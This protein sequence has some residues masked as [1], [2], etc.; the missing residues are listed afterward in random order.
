MDTVWEIPEFVV[1]KNRIK[2]VTAAVMSHVKIFLSIQYCG[3]WSRDRMK[4]CEAMTT[5]QVCLV[6]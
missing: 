1:W 5:F 6:P 4:R 2:L 3:L